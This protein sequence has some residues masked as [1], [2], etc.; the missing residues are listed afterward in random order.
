MVG[1]TVDNN[2]LDPTSV[3]KRTSIDGNDG[4]EQKD[5]SGRRMSDLEVIIQRSQNVAPSSQ[6]ICA[7]LAHEHA[8]EDLHK[9]TDHMSEENNPAKGTTLPPQ[10]ANTQ[11]VNE[12]TELRKGPFFPQIYPQHT[13]EPDLED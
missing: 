4:T 6:S 13:T 3:Q 12:L 11:A 5:S 2:P 7:E 8:V 10:D 1:T 9:V